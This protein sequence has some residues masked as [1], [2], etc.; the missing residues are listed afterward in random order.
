MGIPR[1][2]PEVNFHSLFDTL[3]LSVV[4]QLPQRIREGFGIALQTKHLHSRCWKQCD[5]L[6]TVEW[7]WLQSSHGDICVSIRKTFQRLATDDIL[8]YGHLPLVRFYSRFSDS[9]TLKC[10]W[11]VQKKVCDA[12]YAPSSCRCYSMFLMKTAFTRPDFSSL[13]VNGQEHLL[14]LHNCF[15]ILK[16]TCPLKNSV[17]DDAQISGRFYTAD[18]DRRA[19]S[20]DSVYNVTFVTRWLNKWR[21]HWKLTEMTMVYSFWREIRPL[22]LRIWWRFDGCTVC[23]LILGFVC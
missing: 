4:V 1:Q 18:T 13:I 21:T 8:A 5:Y 10:F 15:T 20:V 12:Q 2:K 17:Q 3:P 11:H 14:Y 22:C 23:M 16:I 6:R 19:L 9:I 7:M